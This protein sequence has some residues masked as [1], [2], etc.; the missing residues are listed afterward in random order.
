MGVKTSTACYDPG[1]M[2]EIASDSWGAAEATA[3]GEQL[4]LLRRRTGM[5]QRRLAT[6]SKISQTTIAVYESGKKSGAKPIRPTA[7]TLQKLARAL[8]TDLAD[9]TTVDDAKVD[10]SY[11][12]LMQ[13]AG[14]RALRDA[15]VLATES[16]GG[17][18]SLKH[19]IEEAFG[20]DARRIEDFFIQASGFD[21]ADKVF[22]LQVITWMQSVVPAGRAVRQR[23]LLFPS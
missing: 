23:H 18:D 1:I 19:H 10:Q 2:V 12:A 11:G 7:A 4:S 8:A 21:H 9:E 17:D 3:F 15:P 13:A 22:I 16:D 20:G 6:L 5:S 14:Y